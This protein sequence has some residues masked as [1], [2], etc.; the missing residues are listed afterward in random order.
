MGRR[1]RRL[2]VRHPLGV[3]VPEPGRARG[4]G[5][6]FGGRGHAERAE[7]VPCRHV[8]SPGRP[9]ELRR[10]RQ[11]AARR[12]QVQ[13]GDGERLGDG[14][15]PD[16][17][18]EEQA[19]S[20]GEGVAVRREPDAEAALPADGHQPELRDGPGPVGQRL[21]DEHAGAEAAARTTDAV[22]S[23][24][25]HSHCR[26]AGRRRRAY[27]GDDGPQGGRPTPPRPRRQ[28][29][30]GGDLRHPRGGVWPIR[31]QGS[32]EERAVPDHVAG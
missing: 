21:L 20:G 30:A 25:Q 24:H 18:C 19:A 4:Q 5:D 31:L 23:A 9:H 15:P 32:D 29:L 14:R 11:R 6:Q 10:R 2:H 3:S 13:T 8:R 22:G 12:R 27:Q 28:H 7:G 1:G 26:R 16:V 17:L